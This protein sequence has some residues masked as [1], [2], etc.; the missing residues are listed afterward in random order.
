M[1]GKILKESLETA[2]PKE[3]VVTENPYVLPGC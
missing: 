3:I 1:C 2:G